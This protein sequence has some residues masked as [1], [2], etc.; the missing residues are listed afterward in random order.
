MIDGDKNCAFDIFQFIEEQLMIIFPTETDVGF[1]D[2]VEE[3]IRPAFLKR[4]S[5]ADG[6]DGSQN[7]RSMGSGTLFFM[8]SDLKKTITPP[9]ESSNSRHPLNLHLAGDLRFQ[10][11]S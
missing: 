3:I 8:N 9:V 11:F 5:K 4:C 2:D 6:S 1:I 7:Q 10:T